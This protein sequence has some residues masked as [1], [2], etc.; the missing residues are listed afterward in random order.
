MSMQ[1]VLK[2]LSLLLPS[3]CMR[4]IYTDRECIQ[5]YDTVV[6]VSCI[7]NEDSWEQPLRRVPLYIYPSFLP[8]YFLVCTHGTRCTNLLKDKLAFG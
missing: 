8:P 2:I 3:E 5:E 1:R 4:K 6:S 7:H